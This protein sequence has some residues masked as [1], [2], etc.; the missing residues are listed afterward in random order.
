MKYNYFMTEQVVSAFRGL[1]FPQYDT[2][3]TTKWHRLAKIGTILWSWTLLRFNIGKTGWP[4]LSSNHT[5]PVIIPYVYRLLITSLRDALIVQIQ[6]ALRSRAR[7]T[8]C[9]HIVVEICSGHLG[10]KC[11]AM[12]FVLRGVFP[13]LNRRQLPSWIV[14][15]SCS[16]L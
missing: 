8:H 7:S 5:F 12:P 1:C 9:M 11:N 15:I 2:K 16:A 6:I 14:Y 13:M 10:S 3:F 4:S